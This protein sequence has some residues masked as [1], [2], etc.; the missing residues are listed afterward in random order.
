MTSPPFSRRIFA[1][2][3]FITVV[4]SVTWP[5]EAM[6]TLPLWRTQTTVVECHC[7]FFMWRED[8]GNC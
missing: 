1:A 8:S 7:C 3:C 6:A 4:P 2:V 5:S